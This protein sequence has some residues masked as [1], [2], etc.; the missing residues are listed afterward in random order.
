M[1]ILTD[2]AANAIRSLTQQPEM[3]PGAGLRIAAEPGGSDR[4]AIRVE[5][6]PDPG[7][8]VVE[9]QGATLFLDSAASAVLDDKALDA[10]ADEQGRVSFTVQEQTP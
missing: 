5:A 7:D 4:L 10:H 6:G 1:V 9:S 8:D 2:Q 3:P